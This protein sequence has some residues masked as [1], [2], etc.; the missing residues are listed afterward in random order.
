MNQGEQALFAYRSLAVLVPWC[1]A[2]LLSLFGCRQ[3]LW[4]PVD[5]S[6]ES[7]TPVAVQ[8]YVNTLLIMGLYFHTGAGTIMEA[9]NPT[10]RNA[11]K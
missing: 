8:L 3:R 7:A 11:W 2:R 10:G 4:P 6:R 5:D 9:G 1:H